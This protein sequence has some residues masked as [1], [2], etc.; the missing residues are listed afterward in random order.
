MTIG[1]IITR[2]VILGLVAATI[3]YDVAAV[4]LWGPDASISVVT[5]DLC[6]QHPYLTFIA[7]AV[8]WHIYGNRRP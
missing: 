4:S 2:L 8:A 7:G 1:V 5:R 3:G 6:E